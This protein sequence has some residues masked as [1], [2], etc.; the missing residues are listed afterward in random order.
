M[1]DVSCGGA[2]CVM[3]LAGVCVFMA[4][5]CSECMQALQPSRNF[6]ETQEIRPFSRS[7]CRNL[8]ITE[9]SRNLS[10]LR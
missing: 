8:E 2:V 7:H 5:L 4:L 3:C 1:C 9:I 10:F 6:C